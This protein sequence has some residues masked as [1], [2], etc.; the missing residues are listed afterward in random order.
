VYSGGCA[1][2]SQLQCE[3]MARTPLATAVPDPGKFM[4]HGIKRLGVR[5]LVDDKDEIAPSPEGYRRFRKVRGE[6]TLILSVHPITQLL[7]GEEAVGPRGATT[8]RHTWKLGLNGWVR[9]RTEIE[10]TEIV[11]GRTFRSRATLRFLDVRVQ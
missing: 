8:A 11:N 3:A 10:A 7:V 6:E 1:D 4:R 2:P 9:D 5:A